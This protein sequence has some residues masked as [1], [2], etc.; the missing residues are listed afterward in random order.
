MKPHNVTWG[1]TPTAKK[2][3]LT[4][5][6][7][8]CHFVNRPGRPGWM[9]RSR[10]QWRWHAK[11]GTGTTPAMWTQQCGRKTPHATAG[12]TANRHTRLPRRQDWPGKS[13]KTR[14]RRTPL[15]TDCCDTETLNYMATS[16]N[17]DAVRQ[18]TA[19]WRWCRSHRTM[20][21]SHTDS[22]AVHRC[23]SGATARASNCWRGWR[24]GQT[25]HT[26]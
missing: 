22:S 1:E 26:G 16:S 5:E 9:D 15:Q 18:P 17:L 13:T 8:S 12:R 14:G 2:D 21:G 23:H 4:A 6:R 10:M 24:T 3:H 7:Q 11:T 19:Q 25:A 20:T